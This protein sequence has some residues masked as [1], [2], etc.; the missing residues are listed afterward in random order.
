VD[1]CITKAL[2]WPG[3]RAPHG[4][5][6]AW[7][8]PL[9]GSCCLPCSRAG[10]HLEPV[11][12]GWPSRDARLGRQ[13]PSH[14]GG[15]DGRSRPGRLDIARIPGR[16]A[17]QGGHLAD[18][19]RGRPPWC[20]LALSSRPSRV[21]ILESCPGGCPSGCPAVGLGASIPTACRV[22][23]GQENK[24]S[25]RWRSVRRPLAPDHP[26]VA[27]RHNNLGR[28]LHAL[29]DLA[30]ARAQLERALAIGEATL[31]PDHP[32]M[33][34]RCNNLGLVLRELEDLAGAKEQLE[35]AVAIGEAALA[36]ITQRWPPSAATSTA[37][38]R[39]S[40][41]D[42]RRDGPQL[43]RSFLHADAFRRFIS[44]L[45]SAICLYVR[46]RC[47]GTTAGGCRGGVGQGDDLG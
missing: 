2:R 7:S 11:G 28:V 1:G 44:L 8:G 42:L 20:P 24:M 26:T 47:P 36:L 39:L 12:K 10:P 34:I 3:R 16:T 18:G 32:D 21:S 38:C 25:G 4:D 46:S 13:P 23:K 22:W 27:T 15:R 33:A 19:R 30:G 5:A 45:P 35:R 14:T 43:S 31:A 17:A 40:R 41:R 6:A 37:S 29:G 9:V